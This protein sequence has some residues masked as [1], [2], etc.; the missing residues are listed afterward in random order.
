MF[1]NFSK[2]H[3][4]EALRT[5]VWAATKATTVAA[6]TTVMNRIKVLDMMPMNGWQTRDLM[7][8]QSPILEITVSVMFY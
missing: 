3:E 7:N 8:G 5:K 1:N 6:F 2:K 4:G